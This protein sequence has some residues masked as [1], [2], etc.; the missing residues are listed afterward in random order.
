M[1]ESSGLDDEGEGI[2]STRLP[3]WLALFL[4][5]LVT[6]GG[7]M[8]LADG[9]LAPKIEKDRKWARSCSALTFIGASLVLL[10]L[11]S[12]VYS[13]IVNGTK[14]EGFLIFLFCI[15]WSSVVSLCTNPSTGLAIDEGGS[16]LYGN[17]YYFSWISFLCTLPL[18]KSFIKSFFF[19]DLIGELQARGK[20]VKMW[21]MMLFFGFIMTGSS[22]SMYDYA[23]RSYSP[24]E[25]KYTQAFCN[26]TIFSLVTSVAVSCFSVIAIGVK[27]AIV[28]IHPRLLYSECIVTFI[29]FLMFAFD[30]AFTTSINGP[31]GPLGNLYYSTWAAM[32]YITL[33]GCSCLEDYQ[34]FKLKNVDDD[35]TNTIDN[36]D[37]GSYSVVDRSIV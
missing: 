24:M 7:T 21:S 15:M 20:R 33:L 29:L 4:S 19:I 25:G 17:L 8:E 3:F 11:L 16:I 2:R 22:A 1:M 23:C 31:G 32:F 9:E 5:S 30:V 10:L 13:M 27:L 35:F 34:S 28:K 14:L 37:H 6:L 12:P 26:R 18:A 36:T